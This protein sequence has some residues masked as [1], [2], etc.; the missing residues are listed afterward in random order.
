[1]KRFKITTGTQ[2]YHSKWPE[3]EANKCKG[4]QSEQK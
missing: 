1:M 4:T 2:N 3:G